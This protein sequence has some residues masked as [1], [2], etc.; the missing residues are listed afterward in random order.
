LIDFQDSKLL[1]KY[2]SW[3]RVQVAFYDFLFETGSEL[4]PECFRER[5]VVDIVSGGWA[6]GEGVY[7]ETMTVLEKLFSSPDEA[8]EAFLRNEFGGRR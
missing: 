1:K 6:D 8:W 7:E 4:C 5:V 3:V 2:G